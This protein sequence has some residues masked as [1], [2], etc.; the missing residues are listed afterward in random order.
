MW[1]EPEKFSG[2]IL[3]T[4]AMHAFAQRIGRAF[5]DRRIFYGDSHPIPASLLKTANYVQLPAPGDSVFLH[6]YLR[7]ALDLGVEWILP[8]RQSELLMLSENN[9]LFNEYGVKLLIGHPS[10]L[11]SAEFMLSPP[12]GVN[13]VILYNGCSLQSGEKV[14]GNA[15][16]LSGVF[17]VADD[18][19]YYPCCIPS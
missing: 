14:A 2:D 12:G 19:A 9:T 16:G 7:F 18:G 15:D 11:E 10:E 3:L 17:I 1:S 6:E 8:L 13:P 5:A 4:G